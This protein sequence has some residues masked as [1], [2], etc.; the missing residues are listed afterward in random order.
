MPMAI[1]HPHGNRGPDL[2]ETIRLEREMGAIQGRSNPAEGDAQLFV[3]PHHTSEQPQKVRPR[4]GGSHDRPWAEP[5]WNRPASAGAMRVHNSVGLHEIFAPEGEVVTSQ[6]GSRIPS[7]IPS[8]VPRAASCKASSSS[9]ATPS[10]APKRR[11]Q[12]AHTFAEAKARQRM[13]EQHEAMQA[14]VARKLKETQEAATAQQDEEFQRAWDN[15]HSEQA[16]HVAD[17]EEFLRL[18]DAEQVRRSN[19]HCQNWNEEVFDKIQQ[20][21]EVQLRKRETKGSYNTRWRHAQDE[22]LHVLTK[23]EPGVFRDIIITDEYDPLQVSAQNIKYKSKR[24]ALKDPLKSE[25]TQKVIEAQ[26]VPGSAANLAADGAQRTKSVLG[27][28]QL[29]VTMWSKMDA[30]PFGH[31]NKVMSREESGRHQE[32]PYSTT[33]VRVLGDHYTRH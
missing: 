9:N 4:G 18:K 12:S 28:G 30:T 25:L 26:M 10:L 8:P 7:R 21:I 5:K 29:P 20:Q 17:V 13:R 16:G 23:K 19:A 24:I 32:R 31:F 14:R 6:Q 1:L 33:G 2:I 22:Y 27:R 15:F 11:P 3:P